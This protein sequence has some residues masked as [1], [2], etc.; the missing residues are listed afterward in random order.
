[1]R[2]IGR[3]QAENEEAAVVV[4][5]LTCNADR[6]LPSALEA[7][8][9]RQGAARSLDSCREQI[10]A[11]VAECENLPL[12]YN[13]TLLRGSLWYCGRALSHLRPGTEPELCEMIQRY[14]DLA[15]AI[16]QQ[17]SVIQQTSR[18]RQLTFKRFD[19]QRLEDRFELIERKASERGVLPRLDEMT[20]EDLRDKP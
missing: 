10:A 1:L 13:Q 4:Y 14:K 11:L 8:C 6:L 9:G 20:V 2:S 16:I 19:L 18:G 5:V 17:T 12:C 15:A 3:W 7:F